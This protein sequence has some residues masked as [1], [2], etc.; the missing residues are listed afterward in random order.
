MPERAAP[1]R[2]QRLP[3][4]L[5]DQIAAG[6]VVERP[7]SVVK[8]L[9]E[10]ALDAGAT[11]LRVELRDGGRAF[12]AVT[13]DGTG[14]TPED[15]RLA[16]E[17]HATSKLAQLEDLARIASYGFRGEALPAIAAVSS[18]R[19]RTRSA[20]DETGL[21]ICVEGGVRR[22]ERAVG[23]PVGTRIEVSEL[24]GNVPA[25]RK[26]LKSETTEWGHAG[27]W[28]ARTAL[29]KPAVH[30]DAT[31]DDRAAWSWPAVSDPLDRVAAVLGERE[32]AA[33][34]A[35]DSTE[36]RVRTHGWVSRPDRHRS[37]LAGVYLF[38]NGRPVRD[39]VLQHALVDCYR[40]V[41][42]RGRFPSAVLFVDLPLEAVDVNVHPAKWE[43]RFADARAAHRWIADAVRSGLA[44]R[45]WLAGSPAPDSS[46]AAESTLPAAT[47]SF[48][49][50]A[51]GERS[52]SD[53]L[54][55]GSSA[56]EHEEP[57]PAAPD[58]VRFGE[59]RL[60][61]QLLATYLLVEGK[62][63]LL[64]VDQHAAHE[65]V[66][67]EQLR[68]S[69]LARGV[70]RQPLLAPL[71][72]QIEPRALA[73]LAERA[74]DAA[75]L[76]FEIE[77][78]GDDTIAVR[79]VPALLAGRDPAGLVRGLADAWLAG[80]GGS[81]PTSDLRSLDAADR[82]FA[83]LACHAARRKGD[84]LDPREQRALLDALDAIPWAPT[85]P[86]GRPVVV[87]FTGPEI[88]RRFGRR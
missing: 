9:I 47:A 45:S 17:R 37:S 78:F 28:I 75:R 67:Y 73:V 3:S 41:L 56:R 13:D 12:I 46:R 14:M 79:T 22:S 38:V 52:P 43:V 83:T 2:V 34:V 1:A 58:R 30:F 26:F 25:R 88:E 64:L 51:E 15:A 72:V 16:L 54:F 86:H 10:N 50:R 48:A 81:A 11:R 7:A 74:E 23:A 65:R 77:P 55:A 8:E 21:E 82:A 27:D 33:L 62:Q 61:G 39:R 20:D 59:L 69:W 76:G 5:I 80:E 31:R 60:L 71:A 68:A 32:A 24:F 49:P 84:P 42:P 36:G 85:C 57:A 4:A 18:L 40:D 53:W 6:E 70:E 29:A 63:D 66:L 87:P 19:L 44:R 35:V